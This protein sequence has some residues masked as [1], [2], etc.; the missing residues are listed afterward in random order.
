MN[1]PDAWD[2]LRRALGD[3]VST[4][5]GKA[6]AVLPEVAGLFSDSLG[7]AATD[8]ESAVITRLAGGERMLFRGSARLTEPGAYE[9]DGTGESGR[10]A[11]GFRLE[12]S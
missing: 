3:I 6:R 8:L 4:L 11:I 10:Y 5:V 1:R 9:I 2:R 12:V 7:S